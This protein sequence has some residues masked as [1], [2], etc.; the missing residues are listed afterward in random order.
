M[1]SRTV[2]LDIGT[3]KTGSTSRQLFL[4]ENEAL[5]ARS[6]V[7]FFRGCFIES[8]HVEL[9]MACMEDGRDS[10]ARAMFAGTTGRA[11]LHARTRE[12]IATFLDSTE[13]STLV[14]S[15]E[16]LSYLRHPAELDRL[17]AFFP[18][19][20]VR[21]TVYLRDKREFLRSYRRQLAAMGIAPSDDKD[22]FAYA[23]DDSWLLD[24]GRFAGIF[25]AR[26]GQENLRT[27]DY[28]VELRR[29]GSIVRHFVEDVLAMKAPDAAVD[30]Y[31]ANVTAARD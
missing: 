22:S 29:H 28:D 13:A 11:D 14:F 12:R 16:G 25:G 3:H 15:A 20:A 9:H 19:E 10:P 17:A 6:G 21:V 4:A 2:V 24:Y 5:L 30:S 8:N 27:F 1:S 26:F 31:W 23:A 18:D 7:A